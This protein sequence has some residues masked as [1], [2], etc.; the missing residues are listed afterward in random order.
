MVKVSRG[1]RYHEEKDGKELNSGKNEELKNQG[2]YQ[3]IQLHNRG[4]LQEIEWNSKAMQE[5]LHASMSDKEATME[6]GMP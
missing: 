1:D 5:K 6:T 4:Y 3:N 2:I